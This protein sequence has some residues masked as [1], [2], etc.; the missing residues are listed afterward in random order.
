M[1]FPKWVLWISY[2]AIAYMP[3]MLISSRA[4]YT[5]D[6]IASPFFAHV[7]WHIHELYKKEFDYLWSVPYVIVERINSRYF[8]EE[9]A[10]NKLID[11]NLS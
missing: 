6:I 8:K 7:A 10:D 9:E 11:D 3:F 1:K 5:I 2:F 4:H